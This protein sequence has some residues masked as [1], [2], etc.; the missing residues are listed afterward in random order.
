MTIHPMWDS[1]PEVKQDLADVLNVIDAN[2]T[3]RDKKARKTILD[4]LHA[5]GKLLRP[6]FFLLSAR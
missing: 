2:I 6:A 4:L 1:Y 3:L 5:G